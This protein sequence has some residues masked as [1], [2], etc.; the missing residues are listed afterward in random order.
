[1]TICIAAISDKSKSII[2]A[3]DR[4]VTA[5]YPPIEFEHNKSKITKI[6]NKCIMLSAGNALANDDIMWGLKNK[7][8]TDLEQIPI[9][10]IAENLKN[11][12]SDYRLKKAEEIYLKSR[13]ITLDIF[14]KQGRNLLLP[15][16]YFQIERSIFTFNYNLELIIAGVDDSG[17][18]IF[19]IRNPGTI[20]CYDSIGYHCIG[21]GS[22]HS[23]SSLILDSYDFNDGLELNIFKVYKSKRNA[24]VAPGVGKLT[25]MGYIKDN[26][27]IGLK[28]EI[29]NELEN[30]Y[31]EYSKKSENINVEVLKNNL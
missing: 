8:K 3:S 9:K 13:G 2:F 28:E 30:L 22:I 21:T 10:Q 12:Y 25:D 20:D 19:G 5:N 15:E 27:I 17:A 29:I 11:I 14:Y 31:N 4:M 26:K 18:H 1:M 24:E 6:S 23:L 16:S 7:I